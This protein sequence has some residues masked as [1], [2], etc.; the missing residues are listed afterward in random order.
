MP[1]EKLIGKVTHFYG[2]INVGIILLSEELNK[3]ER[4]HFVG[5]TTDFE[6]EVESMQVDHS[7]VEEAQT[8]REIGMKVI[9]KVK[10]NDEVYKVNE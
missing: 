1:E 7:E 5:P 8:G 9:R 4:I 3:G 2:K 10:E 6:Q